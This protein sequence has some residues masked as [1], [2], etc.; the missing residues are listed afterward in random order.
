MQRKELAL[1]VYKIVIKQWPKAGTELI[2]GSCFQLLV[3]VILSAQ[4][5]DE[6]VNK[7]TPALFANYPDAIAMMHA[8]IES[9][10]TII[11]STGFYHN[12]AANIKAAAA[13]IIQGFNG[14]VPDSIDE[15]VKLP[16]VGR[17]TANLVVSMCYGK[18]GIVVDTHVKRISNRLGLSNSDDPTVIERHI[19]ES[20]A[21]EY[22]TRFSFALN[23]HGKFVCK[24]R[25]PLCRLCDLAPVCPSAVLFLAQE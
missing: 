22:W 12:K 1:A 17:K 13:M 10:E 19:G 4:C 8:S 14:L 5:T 6:Q 2:H 24:A 11:R 15:L 7:V 18:P 3:S 23:R 16:G 9:L 25:K 20:I 21:E